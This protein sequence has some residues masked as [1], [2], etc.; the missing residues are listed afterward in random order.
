[1][2]SIIMNMVCLISLFQMFYQGFHVI[3]VICFA[4]I[5]RMVSVN[6]WLFFKIY[7][8]EHYRVASMVMSSCLRI[9]SA[10]FQ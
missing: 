6:L 7:I 5:K 1:M 3:L 4:R 2:M 9:L 10:G 8:Y